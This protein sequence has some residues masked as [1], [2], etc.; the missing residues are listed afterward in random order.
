MLLRSPEFGNTFTLDTNAI[1][2]K[3]MDGNTVFIYDPSWPKID[4]FK[5]Q[6]KALSRQQ[7]DTL[8]QFFIGT[9][10]QEILYTDH[11]DR[12][13]LGMVITESPTVRQYGR[14]CQWETEFEFEGVR[15]A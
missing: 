11:E 13:W 12:D 14:G 2:T 5:I 1:V 15:Q 7:I 10:G 6:F 3:S 8:I 4:R 9:A